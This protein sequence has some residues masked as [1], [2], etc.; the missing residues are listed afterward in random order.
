MW[1][2]YHWAAVGVAIFG[3]ELVVVV[4]PGRYAFELWKDINGHLHLQLPA[5]FSV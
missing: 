3:V 2:L 4:Y 1:L 5:M